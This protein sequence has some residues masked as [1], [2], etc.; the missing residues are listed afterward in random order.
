[1]MLRTSGIIG[2]KARMLVSAVAV[3]ALCV[4]VAVAGVNEDLIAAAFNGDLPEV[5]R[6]LAKGAEV[7]AKT[8]EGP[9]ELISANGSTALMLAS[10]RGHLE[11][12]RVL[13]AK[14][15]DVNAKRNDGTTA[16]MLASYRGHRKVSALLIEA[17]A[18]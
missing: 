17:G 11:V 9:N 6:L 15:A 12:V 13:L 18:K 5:Q 1:M 4:T 14:R 7:N 10:W 3:M 2:F 8:N 16:L